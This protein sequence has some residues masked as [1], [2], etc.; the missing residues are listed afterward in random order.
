M[1][2]A[3]GAENAA[4]E[5]DAVFD[6]VNQ[7]FN[8]GFA[9]F[10][11]NRPLSYEPALAGFRLIGLPALAD[12]LIKAHAEI[13]PCGKYLDITDMPRRQFLR[14]LR[15]EAKFS[16][17]CGDDGDVVDAHIK[18]YLLRHDA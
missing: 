1:N 10:F 13:M 2:V 8:G 18:Q 14:L 6:A 9:Q 3:A 15:L 5:I 17:R 7:V 11:F 4:H 12:L 16:K